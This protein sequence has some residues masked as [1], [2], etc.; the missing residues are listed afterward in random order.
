[1]EVGV[2][3]MGEAKDHTVITDRGPVRR[4]STEEWEE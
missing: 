3:T 1:M 4:A 2:D